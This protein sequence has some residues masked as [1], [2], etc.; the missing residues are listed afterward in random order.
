LNRV[1]WKPLMTET[2]AAAYTRGSYYEGRDFYHGTTRE[3]AA[4]ITTEGARLN[5][6]SVNTYGDGFYL[7]THFTIPQCIVLSKMH[8]GMWV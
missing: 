7:A 3:S 2:E 1:E 8:C 6:D 5:S 4:R